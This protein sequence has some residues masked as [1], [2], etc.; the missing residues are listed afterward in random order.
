MEKGGYKFMVI[1]ELKKYY[2]RMPNVLLE[3]LAQVGL[4]GC[5]YRIILSIIRKTYG[6][7]KISDW[8]SVSQLSRMTNIR[9]NHINRTVNKLVERK[10]ILK[11]KQK[12]RCYYSIQP[13][14]KKWITPKPVIAI[15]KYGDKLSPDKVITKETNKDTY[16]NKRG[17]YKGRI[18]YYEGSY[19]A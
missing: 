5:E 3:V 1:A 2:T 7:N 9:T 6:W 13:D 17:F 16:T 14:Y 11:K 10:I 18:K 15:T 4:P 8:I 12:V 19:K